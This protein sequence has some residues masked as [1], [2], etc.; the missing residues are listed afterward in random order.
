M[1]QVHR[2]LAAQS[3]AQNVILAEQK[4]AM[5]AMADELLM[6]IDPATVSESTWSYFEWRQKKVLDKMKL[7]QEKEKEQ[8]EED[9]KKMER[10][11]R[12]KKEE[13]KGRKKKEEEDEK[14]EQSL[15]EEV[16]IEAQKINENNNGQQKNM[17]MR[18]NTSA[19]DVNKLDSKK[20]LA[21]TNEINVLENSDEDIEDEDEVEVEIENEENEISKDNEE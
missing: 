1:V 19:R 12:K 16:E 13:A 8:E 17:P 10:E 5:I 21:I 7:K 3:K 6:Q 11:D 14:N 2:D 4:D 9:K 20:I 18:K 15:E